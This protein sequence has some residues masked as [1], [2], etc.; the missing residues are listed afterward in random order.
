MNAECISEIFFTILFLLVF[1]L[2]Q[3]MF[4]DTVSAL[5]KLFDENAKPILT[6]EEIDVVP[7]RQFACF[8]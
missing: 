8:R 2:I 4:D 6:E 1:F 7:E 5:M 3:K